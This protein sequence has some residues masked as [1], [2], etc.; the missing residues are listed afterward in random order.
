[1]LWHGGG[2]DDDAGAQDRWSGSNGHA[3]ATGSGPGGGNRFDRCGHRGGVG[4][5]CCDQGAEVAQVGQEA[6]AVQGGQ[7][8][9]G[10][11]PHLVQLRPRYRGQ[12]VGVTGDQ[13]DP[14]ARAAEFAGN[15]ETLGE[16]APLGD[17]EEPVE[18]AA[19]PCKLQG[20][21]EGRL[22]QEPRQRRVGEGLLGSGTVD[23]STS[24][25][26]RF[27]AAS[28][29]WGSGKCGST[30]VRSEMRRGRFQVG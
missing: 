9:Q 22:G 29:R 5:E 16:Q 21:W 30:S 1:M 7:V 20:R 13:V 2:E 6:G 4:A 14:Q 18:V 28:P 15:R 23:S 19:L 11:G 24:M 17:G 25:R 26:T 10:R 8:V 27:S 3:T 12:A